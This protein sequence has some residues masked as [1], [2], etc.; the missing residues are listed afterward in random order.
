MKSNQ[1]KESLEVYPAVRSVV[2]AGCISG[3]LIAGCISGVLIFALI[4]LL[5]LPVDE[6]PAILKVSK[7]VA[8]IQPACHF[9][10]VTD[11]HLLRNLLV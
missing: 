4:Q 11:P 6:S 5:T 7:A 2:V 1:T 9:H 10:F 8:L 3:V